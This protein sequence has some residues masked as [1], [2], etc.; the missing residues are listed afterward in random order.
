MNWRSWW[1]RVHLHVNEFLAGA[2][3]SWTL[4]PYRMQQRAEL[5]RIFALLVNTELLGLPLLPPPCRLNLLP[6][7]LPNLLYWRRMSIFDR[8][9]DGADLRHLGH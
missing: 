3:L 9:L 8:E 1:A 7:L 2:S 4:V 6:Y 5:E